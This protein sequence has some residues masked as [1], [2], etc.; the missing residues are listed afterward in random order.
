MVALNVANL[1]FFSAGKRNFSLNKAR[2]E[3]NFFWES[4]DQ[5]RRLEVRE[6][7]TEKCF[8]DEPTSV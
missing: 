2:K 5:F 3:K 1:F 4:L 6:K 8:C 7:S